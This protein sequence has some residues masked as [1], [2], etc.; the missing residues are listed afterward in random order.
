LSHH[1]LLQAI[2]G[3][4]YSEE[5]GVLQVA[6]MQLRKKIEP[7]ASLPRYIVTIPWFG[8]RFESPLEEEEPSGSSPNAM[9]DPFQHP[10]CRL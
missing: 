7:D 6:I 3:L 8:Y 4:E 2:W 1:A 9:N 5:S 10:G